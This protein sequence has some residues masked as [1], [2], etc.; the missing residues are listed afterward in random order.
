MWGLDLKAVGGSRPLLVGVGT[1]EWRVNGAA[2]VGARG[3]VRGLGLV[4]SERTCLQ[5]AKLALLDLFAIDHH[6]FGCLDAYSDL[7]AFDPQHSEHDIGTDA[8][9]FAWATGQN[10]H[11]INSVTAASSRL[12]IG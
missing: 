6:I 9:R 12:G 11:D 4:E 3:V 1:I 2:V 10:E 7:V 5:F 8:E